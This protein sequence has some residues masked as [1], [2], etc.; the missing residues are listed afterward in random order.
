MLTNRDLLDSSG[1]FSVSAAIR[2]MLTLPDISLS[3]EESA[4]FIE[5]SWDLSNM[6]YYA[7]KVNMKYRTKNV[8]AID[9]GSGGFLVPEA[10]FDSTKI[11]TEFG[12]SNILLT[13]K[14]LRGGVLVKDRDYED[15]TIGSAA[16]F[17]AHLFSMIA[18]QMAQEMEQICWLSDTEDLNGYDVDNP[19]SVFDGWRYWLDHSQDGEDYEN[20]STGS[21]IILD[22]SNTVTAA[23]SDFTVVTLQA[24]VENKVAEPYGQEIKFGR[25]LKE[26]PSQYTVDGLSDL[27]FFCNDKVLV[28]YTEMLQERQTTLGDTAIMG[29]TFTTYG[30]IPIIPCPLMPTT[31][32]IDTSDVQKEAWVD[33]EAA[34]G[35]LTDSYPTT[36][37]DLLDVVLTKNQNFGIGIHLE[38]LMEAERSAKDRGNYYYFTTRIDIF[39]QDVHAAVLCKRMKLI[40]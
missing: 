18:K 12:A 25:M 29:K 23:A 35:T 28:D 14:E 1:H 30:T 10:E 40:E 38:L 8:R 33:T 15:L 34:K 9:W 3:P 6:K 36:G 13:S 20:D 21:T 37:G 32:K 22:A 16:E 24:I 27:R 7:R 26:L 17:K 39:V 4:G 19:K 31:M 5:Y 2:K 11:K